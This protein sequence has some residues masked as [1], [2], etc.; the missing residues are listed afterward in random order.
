MPVKYVAVP[1][2]I[3]NKP[4][5][6]PVYYP[7]LKSTG[8]ID[9]RQLAEDLAAESTISPIDVAAVIEGLLLKI[10]QYLEDGKIVHLGEFGRFYLSIQA[11]GSPDAESV[12]AA[13]IKRNRIHFRAG[14]LVQMMLKRV[15]YKKD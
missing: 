9:L 10:P 8:V 3:P 11:E 12:S 6:P 1:N 15:A 13:K 2:K 4:D 14:K 5:D 7:R